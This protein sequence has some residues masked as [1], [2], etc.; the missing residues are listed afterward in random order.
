[1]TDNAENDTSVLFEEITR[2]LAKEISEREQ[3]QA[4][5]TVVRALLGASAGTILTL[6]TGMNSPYIG[7]GVFLGTV[8]VVERLLRT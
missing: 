2:G 4:R 8:L 6:V 1:M 5:T 7:V 3:H